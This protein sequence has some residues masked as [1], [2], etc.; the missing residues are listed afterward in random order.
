MPDAPAT[1]GLPDGQDP[2]PGARDAAIDLFLSYNSDD[3]QFVQAV[4][5]RLIGHGLTT[6][7][8][9]ESFPRGLPWAAELEAALKRAKAVG[10]FLGPNGL[11][12][13]QKREMAFALDRQAQGEKSGSRLPVIPVLMPG[14]RFDD[15]THEPPSLLLLNMS[16]DLRAGPN[17]TAAIEMLAGA[18]RRQ[19]SPPVREVPQVCPYR[20]LRP[21][22]EEDAP[23]F[24]GREVFASNLLEKTRAHPLVAVVGPSGSGKSS[25]V[26]AGLVPL[27][28]KERAPQKTWGVVV[29]TP[30]HRPFHRLAAAL[31][32]TWQP[33]VSLRN[34]EGDD[35]GDHFAAKKEIALETAFTSALEHSERA[36]RLLLVADQCEELFTMTPEADRIP[37]V[38]ALLAAAA[39]SPVTLVLTLRA[40]FYSQA[41]GLSRSLSDGIGRG[42]VNLGAMEPEELRRAIEEPARCVGLAFEPGLVKTILDDVAKRP[43]SLPLLE[44]ALTELW[45]RKS[46]GKLRHDAYDATGGVVGAIGATAERVFARLSPSDQAVALRALT[47]LVRVSSADE[48]GIDTRQRVR[49]RDLGE[50]A[51]PVLSEFVKERLLVT[52]R[53]PATKDELIEVAHEALIRNW[54][55]LKEYI[56]GDREFL[57]WRQ[58]RLG[59]ALA[60]WR[61]T[62]QDTGALL[63]GAQLEEARRRVKERGDELNDEERGFVRASIRSS[64]FTRRTAVYVLGGALLAGVLGL[65]AMGGWWAWTRSDAYQVRRILIEAPGLCETARGRVV[66]DWIVIWSI[67]G[68]GDEA[69][70]VAASLADPDVASRALVDATAALV[71]VGKPVEAAR[72]AANAVS[73]A[74]KIDDPGKRLRDLRAAASTL[75]YARMP[76]EAL[77]AVE[78]IDPIYRSPE[79]SEVAA[80]L[81]KA[82][83]PDKAWALAKKITR[84][85][86][87]ARVLTDVASALLRAGRDGEAAKALAAAKEL[88]VTLNDSETP[89]AALLREAGTPDEVAKA[90]SMPR[91][92][93]KAGERTLYPMDAAPSLARA[94]KRDEALSVVDKINNPIGKMEALSAVA[95]ELAKAGKPDDALFVA[96]KIVQPGVRAEAL[97]A[98]AREL[99]KAGKPDDALFVAKA[100]TPSSEQ[101]SALS[102]AAEALA[103]AERP[104]EALSVAKKLVDPSERSR[105]LSAVAEAL[106][107]AG[108]RDDAARVAGAAV[109]AAEKVSESFLRE[110]ALVPAL[111]ALANAGKTLQAIGGISQI[112][113]ESIRSETRMQVAIAQ[114]RLGHFLQAR[115]TAILCSSPSDQLS[116]YTAIVREYFKKQDSA[117]EAVFKKLEAIP[118][119]SFSKEPTEPAVRD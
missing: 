30:G 118:E 87:Q 104:S 48:E 95:R 79:L 83:K 33:N 76:D 17:D 72:A 51:H 100:V 6:F 14:F 19:T 20:G 105:A 106:T 93:V 27:L 66:L 12:V 3:Y 50:P 61:R 60:E 26:Q 22:R 11:G 55:R 25:V 102:A 97:S 41:I 46:G 47:R 57:L 9:R 82:D 43:G 5:Q 98:A 99:A 64:G 29:F 53:D 21:F 35:L 75:V 4:R 38:E 114:A 71:E 110:R 88:A 7:F 96:D 107:K 2:T 59:F 62:G 32:A 77:A 40:D 52:D 86:L 109:L 90:L 42:L 13:W 1:D 80:A 92:V 24:F 39:A 116:A 37:F 63:R 111:G 28:R 23:L 36:D 112:T 18:T 89:A 81:A 94:G 73:M 67:I 91:R 31:V 58:Q 101:E 117:M 8:D 65:I 49:F 103:K 10:V 68:R 78:E 45:N 44:Y 54:I 70:A 113:D 115:E 56:N 69:M 15:Q 119:P 34:K 85:V 16:V 74:K 108:K 84:P